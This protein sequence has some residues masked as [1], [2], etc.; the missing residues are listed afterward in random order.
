MMDI[1]QEIYTKLL[2]VIPSL[3]NIGAYAKLSAS[4]FMDLHVDILNKNGNVW[5]ISLAHNYKAGGD[6]IPDPDME[7]TVDFTS[8][9]V[10]AETYQDTYVYREANDERARKEMNEFLF[11][12]LGNLV[13][14]GH[15]SVDPPLSRR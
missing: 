13:E 6:V 8:K 3:R 4:G 15:K 7:V 1:A 14:Q 2:H 5:R 11:M 10:Q 9:T 12:W